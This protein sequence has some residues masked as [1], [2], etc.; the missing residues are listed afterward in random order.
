MSNGNDRHRRRA[1][2]R[3]PWLDA[4]PAVRTPPRPER[5]TRSPGR[6]NPRDDHRRPVTAHA[7]KPL[8]LAPGAR[9][10]AWV[11]A[12]YVAAALMAAGGVLFAVAGNKQAIG[13][14]MSAAILFFVMRFIA[15]R[16]AALDSNPQLVPILMGAFCL[17]L[18]GALIRY[19]VA[20]DYYHSG[21]F[22]SY[23]TWGQRIASGLRHGHLISIKG[24]LA[25]TN[26][27]RYV[28]GYIYVVTPARLLSGFF[29]YAFLSFIG[30]IF[31]WRAYRVA[32][33]D[34]NDLRY[35]KWLVLLPSLVYWPSAIGKDA[36]IVLAAGVASYG[37]AR[38]LTGSFL[39][40]VAA[41]G[42][43]IAGMVYVRPHVALVVI[44]GLVI[45]LFVGR[46][47]NGLATSLLS[48]GLVIAL[49][50]VVLHASSSFF[51]V[52]NLNPSNIAKTLNDVTT[53]SGEGG[54]KFSPIVASNPIKYWGALFTVLYRPLPIEAHSGPELL[55]SLEGVVLLFMTIKT[56]KRSVGAL[57]TSRRHPYFTYA[58]VAILVFG[59]AFSGVSNFGILARERTVIYPLLL[60]FLTLPAPGN[61]M[62]F[63]TAGRQRPRGNPRFV[64][65]PTVR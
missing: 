28:T 20:A 4:D 31:F 13:A 11:S 36:F 17:K 3:T 34:K 1:R 8:E 16:L 55:T 24:R 39:P 25:G 19:W 15:K 2:L 23:D 58:F 46:K 14:V 62:R 27:M 52:S 6:Q 30:L 26:F 32:I 60:V 9:T 37:V 51:G 59:F 56:W 54:S 48:M 5:P 49:G 57:R 43:G 63:Q 53:Q 40:A 18:L 29:V 42:L 33:S 61:E 47:Q 35:L 41:L 44:A 22:F 50:F 10:P 65:P 21:D 12:A 7:D 64:R 38:L 45:A